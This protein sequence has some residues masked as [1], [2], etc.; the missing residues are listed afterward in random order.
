MFLTTALKELECERKKNENLLRQLQ[1]L[2]ESNE[3]II[4]VSNMMKRELEEMKKNE[5]RDK[6]NAVTLRLEIRK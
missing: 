5:E 1:E 6:E 4:R 3:Q 2:K